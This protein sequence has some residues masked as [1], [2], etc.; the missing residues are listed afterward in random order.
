MRLRPS[1]SI[2]Y[3][4]VGKVHWKRVVCLPVLS[5]MVAFS[6]QSSLFA[7]PNEAHDVDAEKKKGSPMLDRGRMKRLAGTAEH[8]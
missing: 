8:H 6:R 2:T 3:H 5:A 7:E 1:P 4:Q